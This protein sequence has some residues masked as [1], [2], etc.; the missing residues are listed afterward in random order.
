MRKGGSERGHRKKEPGVEGAQV[1]GVWSKGYVVNGYRV[2]GVWG[3]G[4]HSV[5]RSMER[6][7]AGGST[8]KGHMVWGEA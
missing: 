1:R 2:K 8:G 7:H 6:A 4:V 5:G 3:E